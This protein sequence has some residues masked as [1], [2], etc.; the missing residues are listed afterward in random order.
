M[1]RRVVPLLVLGSMMLAACGGGDDG[2]SSGNGPDTGAADGGVAG[3]IGSA[4]CAEVAAAMA[5]AAQS[6]SAAISGSTTDLEQSVQQMEAFAQAVPDEIRAQME[7]VLAGYQA[8]AEALQGSGYDPASGEAPPP[9]VIAELQQVSEQ[10]Q[11]EEFQAAVEQ[12][13]AYLASG[14]QA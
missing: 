2:G 10:L 11:S 12:V 7:T 13:N 14:C 4:D 6:S 9:E 5:A 8:I 1:L 3:V